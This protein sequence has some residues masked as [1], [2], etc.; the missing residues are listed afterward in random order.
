MFAMLWSTYADGDQAAAEP[1]VA[2]RARASFILFI[3]FDEKD[4]P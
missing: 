1:M 2:T 4:N 3:K